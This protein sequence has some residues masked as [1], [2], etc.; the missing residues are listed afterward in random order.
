MSTHTQ[1]V[2]RSRRGQRIDTVRRRWRG[3]SPL[4]WYALGVVV[5]TRLALLLVAMISVRVVPRLGPY[6]AQLYDRF[7]DGHPWIAGWARWD[8][9]HYVAVAQHG[10]GDPASPSADGGVGFFPLYPGLMRGVVWLTTAEPTGAALALAGIGISLVCL[11]AAAPLFAQLVAEQLGERIARTATLLLCIS[12]FAFFFNTAYSE[13]L[14][15]LLVLTALR[16]ARAGE[17]RWA[18]GIAGLASGTRLVGLALAPALVYLAWRRGEPLRELLISVA[19]SC[20]GT[21]AFFAYLWTQTGSPF[22]Y[23]QAQATWGGWRNFVWYYLEFLLHDPVGFLTGDPRRMI[24]AVNI[25]LGLIALATLPLVWRW[26]D[27]ATATLTT[28]LVV[29]QFANTWVSL[30]RYLLPAVGVTIVIAALL[31]GA[32]PR[33]SAEVLRRSSTLPRTSPAL[34]DLVIAGSAMAVAT[35]MA[36]FAAGFWVI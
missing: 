30:G 16:L 17:W 11:L 33:D 13:S 22:A 10:Y 23:F 2:T 31:E 26:L 8:V 1:P 32:H 29:V 21:V 5:V 3:P 6:P 34:R 15:L 35:L 27:G 12:P 28:L 7:L 36:L 25:L 14:F 9:A 20:W 24:I 4:T 19:I 18:A